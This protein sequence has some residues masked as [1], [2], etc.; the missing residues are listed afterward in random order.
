MLVSVIIPV[1]NVRPYLCEALDSVIN[2]T[3]KDLEI[4]VIDDGSTDGSGD[5]CD[6]YAEKDSRVTVIHQKN[7]G[8]ST[9][10]NVCLAQVHGD[11]VAF[12]DGDDAVDPDFIR[13][14]AEAMQRE[15]ADLVF[16]RFTR[17]NTTGVMRRTG[18]EK[19]EPIARAGA[20]TRV[21]A[22]RALESYSL[23]IF[24][25]VKLYAR[26]LWDGMRFPDGF[27]FEDMEIAYKTIDMSERVYLLDAPLYLYRKRPGSITQTVSMRNMCDQ[28]AACSRV[29][30][31]IREHAEEI[32]GEKMYLR[33]QSRVE[34]LMV[35]YVNAIRYTT[36][37]MANRK[38]EKWEMDMDNL[39]TVMSTERGRQ[40]VAELMDLCGAGAMGGSGVQTTDFYLIGRRS[41]GEDVLHAI[42]SIEAASEVETDGLTLEYMMMREHKRRKELD[43]G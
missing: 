41:V 40:F 24:L 33:R 16:C 26:K 8:L 42:R 4:I 38:A 23:D 14:T 7:R 36:L 5:I 12:V 10:R 25:C 15:K 39:Q 2:Q 28:I 22:L 13:L 37:R 6:A 1:Y 30:D 3:H 20:Y 29:D 35:K 18:E 19:I 17:H 27:V 34:M 43:N 21:E 32:Y 9:A 31:F 11:A